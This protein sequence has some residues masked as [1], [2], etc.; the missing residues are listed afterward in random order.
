[1]ASVA[2]ISFKVQPL[3][4]T[5]PL[6]SSRPP[7]PMTAPPCSVHRA[8]IVSVRRLPGGGAKTSPIEGHVVRPDRHLRG[9]IARRNAAQRR[10]LRIQFFDFHEGFEIDVVG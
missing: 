5:S 1:M 9:G 7:T 8:A 10:G 2:P 3:N 6:T 4:P